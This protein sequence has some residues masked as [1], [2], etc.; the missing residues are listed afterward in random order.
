MARRLVVVGAS[1]AG[2]R[3]VEGARAAGFTG[4]VTLV[5]AE[6]HPPYD[7][8]PLSKEFLHGGA[9]PAPPLHRDPASYAAELDADLLLGEPATALDAARRTVRVGGADL[10]YDALVIATGVRPRALPGAGALAGV[11]TLRTLDDARAIRRALDDGART[12]VVG[13]GFI[14]SEAAAAARRRGLPVT[15]VEALPTPLAR[16]VGEPMG[17]LCGDLHAA[18]GVELRC[19]APVAA[20]EG[21]GRVERV[22]LADGT[23]LPAD[24][25]VVGVGSVPAT[26]WLAGSGLELADG[27]VCDETLA[28]APG[29]YAAG[30]V[31]R[32]RNPLFGRRM[33]LEH[34]TGAAQQGDIAGRNAAD[35]AA[36]RPCPTVPYF[37]SDLY[38]TRVQFSGVPDADRVE[39]FG[40]PGGGGF[41]ALYCRDDRLTGAL[42]FDRPAL[43]LRYRALIRQGAAFPD[44]VEYTASRLDPARAAVG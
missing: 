14:G 40:D 33:R 2:L 29:V 17:R 13:A 12:V 31:A 34:W 25:V 5:G 11:H 44:A 18:N 16:A 22:R 21:R 10:P 4:P 38:G 23:V 7:R 37:W 1:L 36:A 32:W 15:V 8:P 24:L 3:A 27:V 42:V 6:P 9:E 43:A 28:A 41:A 20:V 35:P 19:G 39:C 26:D 30:D